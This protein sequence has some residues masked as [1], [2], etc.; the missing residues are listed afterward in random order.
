MADSNLLTRAFATSVK[1]ELDKLTNRVYNIEK[2]TDDN[3]DRI[4]KHKPIPLQPINVS[5]DLDKI[6]DS[7]KEL[8]HTTTVNI[9]DNSEQL[10]EIAQAVLGLETSTDLAPIVEAIKE[11]NL[12]VP[13]NAKQLESLS[14]AI[15]NIEMSL[16][17]TPIVEALEKNTEELYALRTHTNALIEGIDSLYSAI[18]AEKT[19]V[20]DDNGRIT[21]VKVENN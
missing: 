7:I 16:D 12:T 14:Q 13:D 9:P 11:L 10:L 3:L 21:S 2:V 1:K 6:S 4:I 18:T 15:Q 19:V 5:V 20:Y 17:I 8:E